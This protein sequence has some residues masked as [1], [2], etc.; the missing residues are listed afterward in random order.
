[1]KAIIE[2][3]VPKWQIGEEVTIHF[4]DTMCIRGVVKAGSDKA[5]KQLYIT[6]DMKDNLFNNMRKRNITSS[7]ICRYIG[8]GYRD[9]E[10]AINGERP[11][12]KSWIRILKSI[13]LTD[14]IFE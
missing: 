5:T 2:I 8:C 14:N 9:W 6:T 10:L 7:D 13:L 3:D 4:P 1:M 11:F 12:Y